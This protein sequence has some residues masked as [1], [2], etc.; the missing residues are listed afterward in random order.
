MCWLFEDPYAAAR[1]FYGPAF[2]AMHAAQKDHERRIAASQT[3]APMLVDDAAGQVNGGI[4]PQRIA[5]ALGQ[6]FEPQN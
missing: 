2:N 4:E 3:I 5:W 6:Y 1:N